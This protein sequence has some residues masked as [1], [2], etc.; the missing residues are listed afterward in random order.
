MFEISV[1]NG[2]R[3]S[4]HGSNADLLQLMVWFRIN[5]TLEDGAVVELSKDGRMLEVENFNDML[6]A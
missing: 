1:W 4:C 3:L 5:C 2:N 6:A